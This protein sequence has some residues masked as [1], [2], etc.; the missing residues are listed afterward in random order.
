MS[1]TTN[2]P[3]GI[4][5]VQY[6]KWTL[7]DATSMLKRVEKTPELEK[8]LDKVEFHEYTPQEM[9][10]SARKSFQS[11][12][13]RYQTKELR[14]FAKT[15]YEERDRAINDFYDGKLSAQGLTDKFR[16]LLTRYR[17]GYDDRVPLGVDY[18]TEE[19]MT[20]LFYSD[21]RASL[22]NIAV[23]RNNAEGRQYITGRISDA[24]NGERNWKYY[25]SDYYFASE[26]ALAAITEGL[27]QYVEIRKSEL[28]G[29]EGV[30][31]FEIDIPDYKAK[32]MDECYNFNSS[33]SAYTYNVCYRGDADQFMRD[34]DQVPPKDFEWFYQS[35]GCNGSVHYNHPQF[36]SD[37]ANTYYQKPPT[38]FDPEDRYSATT[39]ASYT[40][41]NGKKHF[42]ST[43]FAY[44]SIDSAFKYHSQGLYVVSSL[45]QF[46][47]N[48]REDIPYNKFLDSL[49]VCSKGYYRAFAKPIDLRA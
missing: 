40:D 36:I 19:A 4:V 20:E 30:P 28:A 44:R 27:D 25:N 13:S 35:G 9:R 37:G 32:G 10:E 17:Q 11:S 8:L 49:Q 24:I 31:G 21:F 42:V 15:I 12:I 7:G 23:E 48:K 2:W 46:T 33:W 1:E 47:G 22:L 38:A 6:G 43:D 41:S 45:L 18:Y 29:W 3:E 16:D 34:Y 5:P 14:D 26:N 39:W